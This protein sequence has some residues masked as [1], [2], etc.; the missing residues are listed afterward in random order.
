MR[1]GAT[2][3]WST[4]PLTSTPAP[5][6]RARGRE[7]RRHESAAV[8]RLASPVR[9]LGDARSALHVGGH[10]RGAEHRA[11]DGA[12]GVGRHRLP[13]A[14]QAPTAEE[15]RLPATPTSVPTVSKRPRKKRTNTAGGSRGASARGRSSR[16]KVGPSDG[17]AA[18]R[19]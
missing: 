1:A 10:R 6:M 4:A 18:T 16:A 14:R 2:T 19:P 15:A 7:E 3:G 17:G 8:T 13:R 11:D 9:A 12:E 5:A